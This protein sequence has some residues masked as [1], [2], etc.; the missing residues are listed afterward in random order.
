[1]RHVAT[2]AFNYWMEDNIYHTPEQAGQFPRSV[3]MDLL[4]H[5]GEGMMM[6][7]KGM[8]KVTSA[9]LALLHFIQVG[10]GS[11][12]SAL[13]SQ[14]WF[15]L[16]SLLALRTLLLIYVWFSFFSMPRERGNPKRGPSWYC[17]A[18]R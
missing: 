11:F 3:L 4:V 5:H 15:S 7:T 14:L 17:Y 12:H 8:C 10:Y 2:L 1:M 18:S 16:L 9:L 13:F 6:G